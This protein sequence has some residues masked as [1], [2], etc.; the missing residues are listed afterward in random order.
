MT[1]NPTTAGSPRPRLPEYYQVFRAVARERDLLLVDI[2][3]VWKQKQIL[4]TD[5]E[6]FE[7]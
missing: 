6:Y 3:P 2:E 1:T 4:Q 5:Q 7:R